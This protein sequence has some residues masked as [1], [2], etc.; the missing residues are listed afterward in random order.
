[1]L[2]ILFG[3]ILAVQAEERGLMYSR[4][5]PASLL[6]PQEQSKTDVETIDDML[7]RYAKNAKY[8]V[9]GEVESMRHLESNQGFDRE[10][11][12]LVDAWYR[13]DGPD[14]IVTFIPYNAPYLEED[15]E[16]VPGKVVKGYSLVMFLDD[17]YRV[18]E[19]NAI[20]YI[21]GQYLWR[22][23]RDGLFLNPSYDREW[24]EENPYEDYVVIPVSSMTHWLKK[25]R[26]ASWLR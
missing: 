23:K 20:F 6:D 24:Q 3:W 18:L 2:S 19:G 10:A 22:N 13:G 26:P 21:D 8:V 25:Q 1:M 15:W 5:D 12:V 7:Q 16:T 14:S 4:V 11:I 17:Q 9:A